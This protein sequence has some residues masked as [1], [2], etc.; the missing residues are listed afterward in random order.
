MQH[1]EGRGRLGQDH[2]LLSP[3]QRQIFELAEKSLAAIFGGHRHA[4][5]LP[6][7]GWQSAANSLQTSLPDPVPS[8]RPRIVWGWQHAAGK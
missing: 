3:L 5:K 8:P 2:Q 1:Y 4:V 6:A 7:V